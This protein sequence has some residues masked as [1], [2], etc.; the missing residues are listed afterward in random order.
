[1]PSQ[2]AHDWL[3]ATLI[4]TRISGMLITA[5][6]FAWQSAPAAI[7]VLFALMLA[8]VVT[9]L[10]ATGD[11]PSVVSLAELFVLGCR[12]ALLGVSIGLAIRILFAGFML[13][14]ALAG[15]TSGLRMA[16]VTDPENAT[17]TPVLSRFLEI[18]TLATFFLIGGHRQVIRVLIDS[19]QW[20]PPGTEF[21]WTGMVHALVEIMTQSFVVAIRLAAPVVAALLL[22]ILVIGLISRTVPQLN[23]LSIG[24]SFQSLVL[25]AM[26]TC[27]LGSVSWVLEAHTGQA[28]ATLKEAFMN[29]ADAATMMK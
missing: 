28:L 29:R 14:G 11:P 8:V 16:N 24:L 12:E 3:L 20:S 22:T 15:Q 25:L 10:V 27:S 6:A 17:S 1:M 5:P 13:S 2:Y 19:L 18:A 4:F 7:R 26:L 21:G 23:S 9:P